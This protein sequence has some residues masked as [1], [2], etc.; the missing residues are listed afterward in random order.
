MTQCLVLISVLVAGDEVAPAHVPPWRLLVETLI[1]SDRAAGAEAATRGRVDRAGDV[2]FQDDAPALT[3][4]D[5][6]WYRNGGHKR[7]GVGMERMVVEF[8]LYG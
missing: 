5:W 1:P 4:D 2:S 6:I 3:F 7:L 8:V